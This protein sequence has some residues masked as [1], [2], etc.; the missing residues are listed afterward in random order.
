MS[1]IL[2]YYAIINNTRATRQILSAG[3]VVFVFMLSIEYCFYH[4][5]RVPIVNIMVPHT[6]LPTKI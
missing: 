3:S 2:L 1:R 4:G 6:A 5:F